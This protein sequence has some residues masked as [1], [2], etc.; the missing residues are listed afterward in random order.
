MTE[1]RRIRTG[2]RCQ[3][4]RGRGPMT[5]PQTTC[6]I[7]GCERSAL[8]SDKGRRG[9]CSRHYQRALKGDRAALPP[10]VSDGRFELG[11]QR[12]K[13][14]KGVARNT[15]RTRFKKG[16]V[17]WNA[18]TAR[19]AVCE[20]CGGLCRPK[21]NRETRF[22]SIACRETGRPR[23]PDHHNWN[24]GVTSENEKARKSRRYADWRGAI[25]FRD[26]YTCQLCGERGGKLHADHIKPF[27]LFP[28]L[29]FDLENGRTLCIDCHRKT[30]T[31]GGK[32]YTWA[33]NRDLR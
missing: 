15:G 26:N 24:G 4:T 13:A 32:L 5:K 16:I 7:E 18:G 3:R 9:L 19:R 21:G 10:I 33:R 29:R 11:H 14:V 8:H 2:L 12:T 28:E 22:C 6:L 25:F 27:S 30:P 1:P 31:W 23:G 17:P 20:I